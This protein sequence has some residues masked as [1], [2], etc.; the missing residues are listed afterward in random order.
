M[1]PIVSLVDEV[2]W[3]RASA[4]DHSRPDVS[5]NNDYDA[6]SRLAAVSAGILVTLDAGGVPARVIIE[7]DLAPLAARLRDL[8]WDY[9][10]SVIERVV[11]LLL[12]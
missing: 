4:L 2:R 10:A 8:A 5:S 7:R 3:L 6:W 9:P 12:A 11:D 1:T